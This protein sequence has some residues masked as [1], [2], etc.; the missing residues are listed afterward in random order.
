[1]FDQRNVG[2]NKRALQL[3]FAK[4]MANTNYR[5]V[6]QQDWR[7]RWWRSL[8]VHQKVD[9]MMYGTYME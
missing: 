6:G 4:R 9:F 7:Y 2:S 3:R 8:D 5:P 1:M